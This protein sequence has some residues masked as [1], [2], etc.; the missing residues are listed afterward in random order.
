MA[1]SG[2]FKVEGIAELNQL[3]KTFPDNVK[4]RAT[5]SGV[6]QAG[7]R[8]RTAFRRAAPRK[9]GTLR[10]SIGTR[11]DKKTGK[12][13]VG[14]RTRFYYKTLSFPTKRTGMK[15][16]TYFQDT[17]KANREQ[18]AQLIIDNSIKELYREAGKIYARTRASRR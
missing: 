6:R 17:W 11:F 10:N 2:S 12:V 15:L 4:R 8:L 1:D 13:Y 18:A 7:A 3:L 16:N 9:T 14:L 5:D